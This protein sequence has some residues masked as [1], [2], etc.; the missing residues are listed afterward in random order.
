[1]DAAIFDMDG[2]L[3][4]VSSIRY[5]IN[6]KDRRFSGRK[7]FDLFHAG[8]VDCPPN[9]EAVTLLFDTRIR[10]LATIIVTARQAMWRYHTIL[11][12]HEQGLEYDALYMREDG[13]NRK[14]YEVKKDLLKKIR[15]KYNPV[16]AVDDN[17]AVL[18]LWEEHGIPT[19]R[20]PGW[21]E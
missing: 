17:P 4:D 3:C 7:R 15:R 9:E 2:T 1:M 14:D 21:E 11:W 8:S 19:W 5:H 10:G 18:A 13:D 16:L 6:P 20:I 12:L